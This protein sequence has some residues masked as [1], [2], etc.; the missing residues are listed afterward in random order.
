MNK[1]DIQTNL[2]EATYVDNGFFET[3]GFTVGNNAWLY[4]PCD[5]YVIRCVK[6][7]SAW[8]VYLTTMHDRNDVLCIRTGRTRKGCVKSTLTWMLKQVV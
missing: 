8:T 1:Q 7:N 4:Y 2:E 3:A 5:N 6:F